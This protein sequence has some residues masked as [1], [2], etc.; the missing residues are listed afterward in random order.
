MKARPLLVVL[1][2]LA[3]A[4]P[5]SLQS[6]APRPAGALETV[7]AM[8]VANKKIIEQQAATLETLKEMQKTAEQI[9]V[10]AKRT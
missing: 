3:S 1:A 5:A 6:Q 7:K 4:I 10:F 8:E 2:V 9:K